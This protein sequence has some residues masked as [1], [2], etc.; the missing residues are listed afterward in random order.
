MLQRYCSSWDQLCNFRCSYKTPTNLRECSKTYHCGRWKA[1]GV[2]RFRTCSS[3][4]YEQRR[5]V[6]PLSRRVCYPETTNA[7]AETSNVGVKRAVAAA[8]LRIMDIQHRGVACAVLCG[9]KDGSRVAA[10][11]RKAGRRACYNERRAP[12]RPGRFSERTLPAG[13]RFV[14]WAGVML[15][16]LGRIPVHGYNVARCFLLS[17]WIR[18]CSGWA[19]PGLYKARYSTR[20]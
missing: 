8:Q 5:S 18:N 7:H 12:C 9:A 2:F 19:V 15:V 14:V 17:S 10:C 4:R 6:F 16:C 3:R 1:T 20:A 11:L 13:R